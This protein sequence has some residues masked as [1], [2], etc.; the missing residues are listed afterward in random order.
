DPEKMQKINRILLIRTDRIGD[1]VLTTPAA[2]ILHQHD[3]N[4]H[5]A[6]LSKQYTE[7][8]LRHHR[9]IDDIVIYDP[10][11]AHRGL[12]GHLKLAGQ[13]R[14]MHFDVA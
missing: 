2:S 9:H 1:V 11:E 7:P 14:K 4:L 6:F 13:L 5:I 3:P 12:R 8:L 10:L